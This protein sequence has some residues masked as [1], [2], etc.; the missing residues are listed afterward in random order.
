MNPFLSFFFFSHVHA[1]AHAHVPS[2]TYTRT[3]MHSHTQSP[4]QLFMGSRQVSEEGKLLGSEV[5]CRPHPTP[6][7]PTAHEPR[8]PVECFKWLK[9]RPAPEER[10]APPSF[11]VSL[12]AGR[13]ENLLLRRGRCQGTV[14]ASTH[15]RDPHMH[16]RGFLGYKKEETPLA[17]HEASL[18]LGLPPQPPAPFLCAVWSCESQ[19]MPLGLSGLHHLWKI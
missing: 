18:F 2:L 9:S 12:K 3:C 17:W 7:H 13:N 4:A 1:H 14:A 19:H 6:P 8:C 5:G 10:S 15:I 16:E 11:S